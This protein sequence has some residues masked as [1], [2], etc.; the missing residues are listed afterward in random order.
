MKRH[1]LFD[2]II[3]N[4]QVKNDRHLAQLVGVTPSHICKLRSGKKKSSSIVAL[5]IHEVFGLTF[6]IIRALAGDEFVGVPC[7]PKYVEVKA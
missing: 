4:F 1:A 5:S 3:D 7:V 2:M 6:P